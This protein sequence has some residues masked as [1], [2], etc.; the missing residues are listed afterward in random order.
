M[1][2]TPH[3]ID[4]PRCAWVGKH[5]LARDY[6]DRVWGRAPADDRG[7]FEALCIEILEAG[8]NFKLVLGKLEHLRKQYKDFEPKHI[9]RMKKSDIEKILVDPD[10]IR[11]RTKAEAIIHNAGIVLE[12]AGQWGSFGKW[13]ANVSKWQK[14]EVEK[15]FKKLFKFAGPTIVYEF[16]TSAGHWPTPHQ[17]GC[18][19]ADGKK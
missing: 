17:D 11:S 1:R 19:M 16:M 15:E 9:A 18:F 3:D 12:L 2:A 5:A 7:Y 8:L 6:H 14:A 4:L 13:V 10:G